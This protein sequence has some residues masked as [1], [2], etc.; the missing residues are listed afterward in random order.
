[1]VYMS[2]G[3]QL[4]YHPDVFAKVIEAAR[5]T[6]AQLVLSV[7]ELVDAD[8]LPADDARVIAVRYV[9]QLALLRRTH[10]FVSHGGANSVMES[11]ACG[12]PM[13]LS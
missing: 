7:G 11:L 2:L 3:S 13:L 8:L 5:A 1:L 4:Y 9:P 6:P 10:A 12:V